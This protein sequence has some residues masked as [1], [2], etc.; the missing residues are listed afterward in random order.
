MTDFGKLETSAGDTL[1]MES[2]DC[3]IA[4]ILYER[5]VVGFVIAI[6]I[7]VGA[8]ARMTLYLVK[9]RSNPDAIVPFTCS[10]LCVFC[11]MMTN[12]AIYAIQLIYIEALVL[13]IA[14]RY[15]VMQKSGEGLERAGY[16]EQMPILNVS[17]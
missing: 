1:P 16:Q 12:V 4:I 7:F 8:L 15:L 11:F 13:G 2:W 9:T 10:A 14:S 6:L 5:G 3:E 17:E